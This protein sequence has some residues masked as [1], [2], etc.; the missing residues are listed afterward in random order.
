[1]PTKTQIENKIKELDF[2]LTHNPNHYDYVKVLNQKR[3]LEKQ[4]L[5]QNYEKGSN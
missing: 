4:L 5:E 1:M 2:W 3:D